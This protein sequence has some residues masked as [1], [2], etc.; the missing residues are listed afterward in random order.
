MP[1]PA[2]APSKEQSGASWNG[3][4]HKCQLLYQCPCCHSFPLGPHSL[5]ES[6]RDVSRSPG[7][8]V[9]VS[10]RHLARPRQTLMVIQDKAQSQTGC[11]LRLVRRTGSR[12]KEDRQVSQIRAGDNWL[13]RKVFTQ[14]EASVKNLSG[15][16]PPLWGP[17]PPPPLPQ[18]FFP[19]TRLHLLG[20]PVSE[21]GKQTCQAWQ[22]AARL[23]R[24]GKLPQHSGPLKPQSVCRRPSPP[25]LP[26]ACTPWP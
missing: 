11:A 18:L 9:E 19:G 14:G 26:V 15:V 24:V 20:H 1:S 21:I 8:P 10:I 3:Q 25:E 6:H 17:A 2:P 13:P 7:S 16:L 12:H 4:L 22:T 23:I 5:P